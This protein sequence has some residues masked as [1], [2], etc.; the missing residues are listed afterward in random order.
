DLA[1]LATRGARRRDGSPHAVRYQQPAA[2]GRRRPCTGGRALIPR[3]DCDPLRDDRYRAPL[4]ARARTDHERALVDVARRPTRGL[5]RVRLDHTHPTPRG[6]DDGWPV[7]GGAGHRI[8][9]D[10]PFRPARR[11][12]ATGWHTASPWR[13]PNHHRGRHRPEVL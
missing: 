4:R 9:C 7:P 3:W 2:P 11:P 5:L 13:A 8:H 12:R 6:G 1:T 10:R